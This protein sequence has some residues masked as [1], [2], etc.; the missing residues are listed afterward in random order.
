MN[1]RASEAY[2]DRLL[3]DGAWMPVTS[4]VLFVNAHL[5]R[6]VD[7]LVNGVRGSLLREHYGSPLRARP[8]K[9]RSLTALLE[10]LL[11]LEV[12]NPRRILL[13]PTSNPE[14]TAYFDCRAR[15][16]DPSSPIM[17]FLQAGIQSL[18]VTDSPHTYDP[19]TDRGAY[20]ERK[21]GM[22]EID[23]DGTEI[24]HALGV[25]AMNTRKWA[26]IE[27]D[28]EFPVGNV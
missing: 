18:N 8:V 22:F 4:T 7:A 28:R 2:Q 12:G 21:I 26:V 13:L 6:A 10:E 19:A 27:P 24:G 5:A 3:L 1:P 9:G 25:R 23:S 20:G 11:P 17:W 15:G 16:M 14:W